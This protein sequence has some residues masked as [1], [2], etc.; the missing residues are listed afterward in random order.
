[1]LQKRLW[2]A[3]DPQYPPYNLRPVVNIE[4]VDP[5]T[6]G[7]AMVFGGGKTSSNELVIADL[8]LLSA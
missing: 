5:G 1:M 2:E 3:T 8:P 4:G 7:T 6:A